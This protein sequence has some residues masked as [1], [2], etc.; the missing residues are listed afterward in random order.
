MT[1]RPLRRRSVRYAAGVAIAAACTLIG[2]RDS[3]AQTG[4]RGKYEL[5]VGGILAAPHTF[6]EAAAELDRPDGGTLALFRTENSEALGMGL[7]AHV[8]VPIAAGLAVEILG[9]W[10][11][12][13]FR[14]RVRSDFEGTRDL[15]IASPVSRFT[16][17]G[18]AAWT[19]ADRGRSAWFVRG[20]GGWMREMAD[21]RIVGRDGAVAQAGAGVKYWWRQPPGRGLALGVRIEGHAAVRWNG[22]SLGTRRV[23]IAPGLAAGLILGS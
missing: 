17:E 13:D 12:S 19:F 11:R 2:V 3:G 4:T 10:T 22:A 16:V 15:T 20:S 21:R 7:R 5:G 1:G 14:T 23:H 18:G 8:A 6:G 9:G